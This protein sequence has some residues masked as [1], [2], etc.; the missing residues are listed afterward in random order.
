M[1]FPVL[2]FPV[3]C[4]R[5]WKWPFS[6][7]LDPMPPFLF[8]FSNSSGENVLPQPWHSRPPRLFAAYCSRSF[9]AQSP[10]PVV[11]RSHGLDSEGGLELFADD[12]DDDDEEEAIRSSATR[13]PKS[14][15]NDDYIEL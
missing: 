9:R 1:E 2:G 14:P 11:T 6:M 5:D 10:F 4:C 7:P 12:D 8:A 15:V 13:S 3:L